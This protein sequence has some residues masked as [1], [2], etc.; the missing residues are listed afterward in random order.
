MQLSQAQVDAVLLGIYDAFPNRTSSNGT[1]NIS[2][3]NAAPSGTLQ[4]A[5]PP[6]TGKEAAYELVND[7]CGVSGKHYAA[8]TITT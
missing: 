1:L 4:A 2:T 3:T 5:C 6:T 8:V 7:S